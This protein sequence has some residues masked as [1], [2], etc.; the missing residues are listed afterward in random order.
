MTGG[1]R[2]TTREEDQAEQLEAHLG[3]RQGGADETAGRIISN[4][5]TPME[6]RGDDNRRTRRRGKE[7]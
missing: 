6:E 2:T 1:H 7:P 4:H 5:E 3:K